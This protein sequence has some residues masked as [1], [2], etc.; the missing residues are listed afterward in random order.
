MTRDEQHEDFLSFRGIHK[1]CERCEGAGSIMY[2]STATWRGGIGGQAMTWDVC[3][4]CW[5]SGDAT[6]PWTN[7]KR[8]AAMQAT[9]RRLE[10]CAP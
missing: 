2:G 3:N 6:R 7:L 9:L 4:Q 5:G 10:G 8:V 1:Q